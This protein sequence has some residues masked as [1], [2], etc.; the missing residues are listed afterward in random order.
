MVHLSAK[1]PPSR[2]TGG[3]GGGRVPFPRT[4]LTNVSAVHLVTLT[5]RFSCSHALSANSYFQTALGLA[6][7]YPFPGLEFIGSL[8]RG[9]PTI[10]DSDKH[11]PVLAV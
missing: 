10:S 2:R 7:R 5:D 1:T 4:L 3:N 11:P 6:T 9:V 8:R